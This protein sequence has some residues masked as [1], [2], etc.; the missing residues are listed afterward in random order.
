VNEEAL[1]HFGLLRQKKKKMSLD[2]LLQHLTQPQLDSHARN[3]AESDS[4][5]S[6][7]FWLTVML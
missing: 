5:E 3:I 4:R 6:N 2:L 1:A 7:R